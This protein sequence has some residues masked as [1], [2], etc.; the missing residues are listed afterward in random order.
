M[1]GWLKR[2]LHEADRFS[3]PRSERPL[4]KCRFRPF[5][6]DDFDNCLEIYRLNEP[7]RFPAAYAEYYSEWLRRRGDLVLICEAEGEIRA[8]GGISMNRQPQSEVAALTFGMV[9]P[10]YHNQGFGTGL[11]L[12]RI[13]SLPPPSFHWVAFIATTGGSE[14]YYKRFGFVHMDRWADEHG[15]EFDRYRARIYKQ[16]WQSCREGLAFASIALDTSGIVVPPISNL[17]NLIAKEN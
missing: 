4:P 13:A 3:I 15:I 9:H 17:Q 11:L 14:S 5:C 2:L 7:G 6:D 1:I 10:Q 12:A 16:E 8:F